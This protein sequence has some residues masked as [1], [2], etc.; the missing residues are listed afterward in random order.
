MIYQ[1][2]LRPSLLD[3][4][5]LDD[6]NSGLRPIEASLMDLD[7]E[8]K[9]NRSFWSCFKS[10]A[11]CNYLHDGESLQVSNH[12]QTRSQTGYT[13]SA[14]RALPSQFHMTNNFLER[15]FSRNWT[16]AKAQHFAELVNKNLWVSKCVCN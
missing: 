1:C 8:G 13:D 9:S 7:L 4:I 15:L 5:P 11:S 10:W 6:L 16:C 14:L 12:H 2:H 3:C